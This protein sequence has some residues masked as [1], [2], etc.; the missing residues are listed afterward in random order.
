MSTQITPDHVVALRD[1]TGSVTVT[2]VGGTATTGT[3]VSATAD[4]VVIDDGTN[5]V[6]V[7]AA[8]IAQTS[9]AN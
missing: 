4:E 6:R 8:A 5:T 2:T 9:V 1:A 7:R 3:V